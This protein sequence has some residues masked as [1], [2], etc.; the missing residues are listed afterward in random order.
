ML[1]ERRFQCVAAALSQQRACKVDRAP[2][3]SAACHGGSLRVHAGR[4]RDELAIERTLHMCQV[5][6]FEEGL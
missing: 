5:K 3:L 1:Q 6:V 4:S 2:E